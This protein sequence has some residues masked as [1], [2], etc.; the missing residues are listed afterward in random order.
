MTNAASN[1]PF[2]NEASALFQ[3]EAVTFLYQVSK[4]DQETYGLCCFQLR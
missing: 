3:Y 1:P 4:P 2:L